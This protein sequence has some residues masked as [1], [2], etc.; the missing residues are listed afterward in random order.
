MFDVLMTAIIHGE[1]EET[2]RLL[3]SYLK[4]SLPEL[5]REVD[6]KGHNLIHYLARYNH[7]EALVCL[8]DKVPAELFTQ[9]VNERTPLLM[10]A[11]GNA[12]EV[13]AYFESEDIDHLT[14]QNR[15]A[16]YHQ[17]ISYSKEE[18]EAL[19]FI[20]SSPLFCAIGAGNL[21]GVQQLLPL[22]LADDLMKDMK[23]RIAYLM[24]M[25][26]RAI[27]NKHT[28]LLLYLSG[29]MRHIPLAP[30]VTWLKENF[31]PLL[32]VGS[33][34][35]A[36]EY[37]ENNYDEPANIV[38]QLFPYDDLELKKSLIFIATEKSCLK[39]LKTLLAEL[40]VDK[41]TRQDILRDV[42]NLALDTYVSSQS[43]GEQFFTALNVIDVAAIACADD[44]NQHP[45]LLAVL[46]QKYVMIEEDIY[47][48]D[49][50]LKRL[51]DAGRKGLLAHRFPNGWT[52]S[53][54][55]IDY[56]KGDM[57]LMLSQ[58]GAT[59]DW[60]DKSTVGMSARQLAQ[61]KAD[62]ARTDRLAK[63][64]ELE[65]KEQKIIA[66]NKS[67]L[68]QKALTGLSTAHRE[69]NHQ[70]TLLEQPSVEELI[71]MSI[72]DK[73]KYS[74]KEVT[75]YIDKAH[76]RML[77][78]NIYFRM[79][80]KIIDS[81]SVN[82]KVVDMLVSAVTMLR[83]MNGSA[84]EKNCIRGLW[85]SL[86]ALTKCD[87]SA[88]AQKV[89]RS[90]SGEVLTTA[91]T[92]SLFELFVHFTTF[93]YGVMLGDFETSLKHLDKI[94]AL[95]NVISEHKMLAGANFPQVML[96][97][98]AL[99]FCQSFQVA[100]PA[101]TK[102]LLRL[103]SADKVQ[104]RYDKD[105]EGF[106]VQSPVVL[107]SLANPRALNT[108][109]L[110]KVWELFKGFEQDIKNYSKIVLSDDLQESSLAQKMANRGCADI[111]TVYQWWRSVEKIL[112]PEA[113]NVQLPDNPE[114]MEKIRQFVAIRTLTLQLLVKSVDVF[115][116]I[117]K[118]SESLPILAELKSE[119]EESEALSKKIE[120]A[121]TSP[122]V[123][124]VVV[125]DAPP[126]NPF[127]LWAIEERQEKTVLCLLQ[128][129]DERLLF[130]PYQDGI[131]VAVYLAEQLV[132]AG[133]LAGLQFLMNKLS[134]VEK[135]AYRE[136]LLP[137]ATTEHQ[138]E[139]LEYLGGDRSMPQYLL[140]SMPDLPVAPSA[141]LL[142][143]LRARRL[144]LLPD[145][146][147][148]LQQ[149]GV[150]PL[151]PDI[152]RVAHEKYDNL[153][154][155]LK[156][157]I[158]VVDKKQLAKVAMQEGYVELMLDL[159]R[160]CDEKEKRVEIACYLLKY[161][162]HEHG[163]MQ[164]WDALIAHNGRQKYSATV[165]KMFGEQ[166]AASAE[167][168]RINRNIEKNCAIARLTQ[169]IAQDFEGYSA[170]LNDV[171]RIFYGRDHSRGMRE[172]L[173]NLPLAVAVAA[174]NYMPE[175][176]GAERVLS[177]THTAIIQDKTVYWYIFAIFGANLKGKC[178]DKTEE[179][180]EGLIATRHRLGSNKFYAK[181]LETAE[182]EFQ[183]FMTLLNK[184]IRGEKL[185]QEEIESAINNIQKNKIRLMTLD[186][187]LA[188][189]WSIVKYCAE[190]QA[191]K[192]DFDSALRLAT[193][194][195]SKLEKVQGREYLR[196]AGLAFAV[197][198]YNQALQHVLSLELTVYKTSDPNQCAIAQFT[199][200]KLTLMLLKS[201]EMKVPAHI[202][203]FYFEEWDVM[204]DKQ[205]VAEGVLP[206]VVEG[207]PALN[208][209]RLNNLLTEVASFKTPD[210]KKRGVMYAESD[211]DNVTTIF[212]L[213][214]ANCAMYALLVEM[215]TALK[216]SRTVDA[217]EMLE[218][219][220]K[221]ANHIN[222]LLKKSW[223]SLELAY[224]ELQKKSKKEGDKI[225][226]DEDKIMPPKAFTEFTDSVEKKVRQYNDALGE[227]EI[228]QIKK[229]ELATA[230]KKSDQPKRFQHE[231]L[232]KTKPSTLTGWGRMLTPQELLE[233]LPPLTH[234]ERP[235][236]KAKVESKP[237]AKQGTGRQ[238]QSSS[239]PSPRVIVV[240]KPKKPPRQ[241]QRKKKIIADV[242]DFPALPTTLNTEAPAFVPAVHDDYTPPAPPFDIIPR[243][244]VELL[245]FFGVRENN[246]FNAYLTGGA[247]RDCLMGRPL[248][249][250]F[251][252]V[253][254]CEPK[255]LEEI[256]L[257][258]D[259]F[260]FDGI[261]KKGG[262]TKNS[263]RVKY[264]D[265]EIDFCSMQD[266]KPDFTI[267]S[268]KWHPDIKKEIQINDKR[269]A[270]GKLDD[271][272]VWV[273]A[274]QAMTEITHDEAPG[275]LVIDDHGGLKDITD[276]L[277]RFVDTHGENFAANEMLIFR[278]IRF[279]EML[280]F[281]CAPSVERNIAK[282]KKEIELIPS[283]IENPEKL[284]EQYQKMLKAFPTPKALH[285][286]LKTYGRLFTDMSKR[287]KAC[288]E[289]E[290]Q[291]GLVVTA[292]Q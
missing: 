57:V 182:R 24:R 2:L 95:A 17:E 172:L 71:L 39:T 15:A 112:C 192:T 287:V 197:G 116:K 35:T 169:M 34:R 231:T 128:T 161:A 249:N 180:L 259:Q 101:K 63:K 256:L 70:L 160:S 167:S 159:I 268:I 223:M 245:R 100:V 153:M 284:K 145:L 41:K 115:D 82:E 194:I 62:S 203:R 38:S 120:A 25:I 81:G 286:K 199:L 174:I 23:L 263:W 125:L 201:L 221:S 4:D 59:F 252:I 58:F 237:A 126:I 66:T 118:R 75:E 272:G 188:E 16:F 131:A 175:P 92:Q 204:C 222:S 142:R 19:L 183:A 210:R 31:V 247:V 179:T 130:L 88:N 43:M 289:N 36:I 280:H 20:S 176:K 45:D 6:N 150:I 265:L 133:Q 224:H 269:E 73:K 7:R 225:E 190:H 218:L 108:N 255:V 96:S 64:K 68:S 258:Q 102:A 276:G 261:E 162:A 283:K 33:N 123:R 103:A 84:S 200:M 135:I 211:I 278:T 270:E 143:S 189:L 50:F 107:L 109:E 13:V 44:F 40:V 251:D 147:E 69:L 220:Y 76:N 80:G 244:I 99:I 250:D 74:E 110:Q 86:A 42:V 140:I 212:E 148:E 146:I 93:E 246:E 122:P 243:E 279:E 137:I 229:K 185:S 85:K 273:P 127:I 184:L 12:R 262:G 236:S 205:L 198:D 168:T 111:L 119:C 77:Q 47:V 149:D 215:E 29:Q 170:E 105:K 90:L 186:N 241:A 55:A 271:H 78:Q 18:D 257:R 163:E 106:S 266:A 217:A 114:E 213:H 3:Q 141:L 155:A 54:F 53:H 46:L 138:P 52:L 267:N 285:D 104:L 207:V 32:S 193:L 97:R 290:K 164:Q 60:P 228:K 10:A 214:A 136:L 206:F 234:V 132:R 208:V 94:S 26:D 117:L 173:S 9:M 156:P 129:M 281:K 22:L 248:N 121:L 165:S 89:Y 65:Q 291:A 288:E 166:L 260:K 240:D 177:L 124:K 91:K 219:F 87:S 27:E 230:P 181:E 195:I 98:M 227:A 191:A 274:Q 49:T 196:C 28:H 8:R 151:L 139:I 238:A 37:I 79:V 134:E 277:L 275:N 292:K 235:E 232:T 30:R 157:I 67:K 14:Q 158:Y 1:K 56:C 282:H 233:L 254:D 144:D 72:S 209:N 187:C 48:V 154:E 171:L 226:G 152:L 239:Q 51:S 242:K 83:T 253:V 264:K 11:E 61:G 202:T 21:A 216:K 5:C 178:H 113:W